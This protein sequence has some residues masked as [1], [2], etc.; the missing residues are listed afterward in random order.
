MNFSK[1]QIILLGAG[2][3]IVTLIVLLLVGVIPGLRQKG[4]VDGPTGQIT[5][6]GV[7]D[8][9]RTISDTLIAPFVTANPNAQITY[10]QMD[11]RTYEQDLINALAAGTGP[12]VF[13]V[14]N[15]WLTKHADKLWPLPA[16]NFSLAT[17]KQLFPDV[18]IQDFTIGSSMYALPLYVDTLALFYNKAIFDNAG[19]AEPPRTWEDFTELIPKLR[20]ID[21][22][23]Q[24]TRAA[25]A[26]G[27]SGR[28]INS[29]T[30]L[31]NL[32]MLQNGTA[33]TDQGFTRATFA[34]SGANAASFYTDFSNPRSKN[35]TWDSSSHYS[36]DAFAEENVAM[37]FNYAY[38]VPQLRQKNP[39]LN[40]GIAPMLQY[41]NAARQINYPNYF[42]L[43]ISA[44][45]KQK[46]LALAFITNSTMD[47]ATNIGYLNATG[48]PPASR[49]TVAI[50]MADPEIAIFSRQ[51]LTAMDWPKIDD[52]A[53]DT[54]FTKM[55]ELVNSGQ[56]P[57][58]R[59][60]KQT[61]EEI[62]ALIQRRLQP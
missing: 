42:G 11:P 40:F 10:R 2:V 46:D 60:L 12:D 9:E 6:W 8:S 56:L 30:D 37:I 36:L 61:E 29:A 13:Y 44:T 27:G 5:V 51:V 41:K 17:T 34:G 24:L 26:I 62:T 49:Q 38:L 21:A 55:L 3:L 28:N 47:A 45:S 7:Y 59:A 20:I 14:K 50:S 25:A 19:I 16:E 32:I 1:T 57:L 54:S 23:G 31:L 53:I 52:E 39:F 43:G 48:R 18:V 15:S 58:A 33:M 4:A 22:T 35:Y